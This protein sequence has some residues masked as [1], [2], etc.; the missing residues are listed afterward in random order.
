[1]YRWLKSNAPLAL[2][3]SHRPLFPALFVRC[4]RCL[5]TGRRESNGWGRVRSVA[6]ALPLVL[7][8]CAVAPRHPVPRES[9]GA[10]HLPNL[11]DVRIILD[12]GS[13]NTLRGLAGFLK[14]FDE[15][16]GVDRH[17]HILALSGGGENGAY[18]AG[19]LC[20][21]TEAGTRPEFDLVTGISTGSLIAPLAFL[22]NDFDA[23]LRHGYTEIKPSQVFLKR[24]L[25]GILT[26]RDA[27][28]D[29]KPLQ[30]LIAETVGEKEVA[31]IAREHRKGRRLLVMTTNL[32]AQKPVIWDIGAIATSGAPEAVQ[33][34]QKILLASASI[35]VAFPPVLF[36]VEAAGRRYDELH[37]DGGVMAQVFG[38]ALLL[39][40]ATEG[41]LAAPV[42]F[43]LIR[44]GRLNMQYEITRR[45]ISAIAG[46]SISTLMKVQGGSD[47]LRAWM[48]SRSTGSRFHFISIPDEFQ[49]ELKEPFDP[50]YMQ[51]LFDVGWQQALSGI[52]W[53]ETPA[54]LD[55]IKWPA[56]PQAQ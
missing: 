5:R 6:L 17:L 7:G 4:P 22:G 1:M 21:W 54:G 9:A 29:S 48:F 38:G 35:P 40:C 53:Q 14:G 55:E 47:V 16:G 33:L 41:R 56:G 32:D 31:A 45:K 50:E 20:G 2:S 34:I 51:A 30:K 15:S 24:G 19:L 26:H 23:Q 18:G 36:E 42:D 12:P 37:V 8:G 13:T 10:A 28:A 27:V 43:Y 46:R 25:F 11:S 49:M 39:A 3:R 52:P 44:N